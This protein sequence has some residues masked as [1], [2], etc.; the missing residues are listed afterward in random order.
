MGL[1]APCLVLLASIMVKTQKLSLLFC[2]LTF[3]MGS[4]TQI[5]PEFGFIIRSLSFGKLLHRSLHFL[6]G[7]FCFPI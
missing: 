5:Y 4:L 2:S 1:A 3:S 7:L 6:T